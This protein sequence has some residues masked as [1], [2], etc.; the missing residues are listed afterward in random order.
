HAG[1]CEAHVSSA[2]GLASPSVAPFASGTR[3]QAQALRGTL[4]QGIKRGTLV[5]HPKWGKTYVGGTLD[6]RVSLHDRHTGKRLTQGAKVTACRVIKL[7]R[8]RTRLVPFSSTH[9]PRKERVF[10]PVA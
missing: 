5:K 6:G 7:V 4:S 8:W 10:P 1:Q 2:P 3:R 9:T